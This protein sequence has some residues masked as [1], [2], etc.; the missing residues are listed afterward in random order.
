MYNIYLHV[1][2]LATW[3]HVYHM[4]AVHME[5]RDRHQIPQDWNYGRFKAIL[6]VL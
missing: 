1:Y 3:V 4:H 6:Q 2:M 5:A